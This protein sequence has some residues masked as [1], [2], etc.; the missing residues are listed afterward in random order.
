METRLE[1][2]ARRRRAAHPVQSA[3]EEECA[4]ARH[5]SSGARGAGGGLGRGEPARCL[6]SGAGGTFTA[7]NDLA[8]FLAFSGELSEFP[9]LRFIKAL[10]CFEKPLVARSRAM[11]SAS[12]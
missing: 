2:F 4:H 10:A 12:A 3:R 1:R 5:V 11:R 7:G 9:A 8:D 6:F